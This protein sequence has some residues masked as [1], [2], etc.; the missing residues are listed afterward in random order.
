MS[1]I[2]EIRQVVRYWWIFIFLGLALC[3][4]G[5]LLVAFPIASYT[6][7]TF[8]FELAILLNGILEISFAISNYRL[9][10]G[11]GWHLG[12]GLLELAVGGLLLLNSALA[13]ASLSLIVGFWLMFRSI[14]IVGRC[15]DLP[16][17]WPEKAWMGLLGV[18]GL[19]FSFLILYNPSFGAFTL[20]V[21]TSL[22][23][24]SIGLF[25]IFLGI[26]LKNLK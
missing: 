25:Y 3:M 5:L 24:M 11:W 16:A 14:A 1:M 23:L 2:T 4:F 26:H 13:A 8:F 22:A 15:F 18:A 21:W 7:L 6:A 12:G 10:P 20:L 17:L 19:V 9:I